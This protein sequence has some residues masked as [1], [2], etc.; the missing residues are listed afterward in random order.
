MK[1]GQTAPEG[2]RSIQPKPCKQKKYI[3]IVKKAN[4]GKDGKKA[5]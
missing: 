1:S 2:F 4:S 3:G 5:E